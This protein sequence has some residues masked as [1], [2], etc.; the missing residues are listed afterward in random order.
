ML[1]PYC[2]ELTCQLCFLALVKINLLG[3][4]LKATSKPLRLSVAD[5]PITDMR[6]L[7]PRPIMNP[8]LCNLL[9]VHLQ[10]DQSVECLLS[11]LPQGA[12][13]CSL[14]L[15]LCHT[16]FVQLFFSSIRSSQ[17]KSLDLELPL[18]TSLCFS[19]LSI[20][21]V[22]LFSECGPYTRSK[23]SHQSEIGSVDVYLFLHMRHFKL[24][25]SLCLRAAECFPAKGC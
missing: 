9:S 4:V 22:K 21:S 1:R 12:P 25:I 24:P 23:R 16:V 3:C 20:S 19:C 7:K 17:Y 15:P 10:C 6:A 5:D 13:A 8:H 14:G 18:R 11:Q 2:S